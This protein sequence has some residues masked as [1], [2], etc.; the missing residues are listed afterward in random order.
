MSMMNSRSFA[1]MSRRDW[2]L[3][4]AGAGG[5]LLLVAVL[6]TRYEVIPTGT[7]NNFV[8]VDRWTGTVTSCFN[9]HCRPV[10]DNSAAASEPE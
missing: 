3:V 10:D 9:T 4:G 6:W 7:A 2:K 1:V 8:R 5:A